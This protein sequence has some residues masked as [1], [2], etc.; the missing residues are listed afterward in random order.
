M[1]F[2]YRQHRDCRPSASPDATVETLTEAGLAKYFTIRRLEEPQLTSNITL[3]ID[4]DLSAG[5]NFSAD[6]RQRLDEALRTSPSN[7]RVSIIIHRDG[8]TVSLIRE[9]NKFLLLD[10]YNAHGAKDADHIP[11]LEI[12]RHSF[13]EAEIYTLYNKMQSDYYTCR[14]FA[15]E[16][17]IEIERYCR[18]HSCGLEEVIASN[19]RIKEEPDPIK[20]ALYED[21]KL[22]IRAIGIPVP[23]I[24]HVQSMCLIKSISDELEA[25]RIERERL[26]TYRQL[27]E[28][29]LEMRKDKPINLAITRISDRIKREIERD[30]LRYEPI[31]ARILNNPAGQRELS[32]AILG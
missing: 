25:L 22:N 31:R 17:I 15:L 29:N 13:P 24:H 4:Y 18:N 27:L 23:I 21:L 14:I 3:V 19:S 10:S 28:E 30:L 9:G 7:R 20:D 2:F 8:H 5:P 1:E 32:S 11:L 6:M 12:I 26:K 16:N